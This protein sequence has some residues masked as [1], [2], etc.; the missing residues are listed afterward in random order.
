MPSHPITFLCVKY[1]KNHYCDIC[2]ILVV[3]Y[4]KNCYVK[5]ILYMTP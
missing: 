5:K 3:N 4:L 2:N 1:Q